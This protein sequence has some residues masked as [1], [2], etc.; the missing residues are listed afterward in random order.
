MLCGRERVLTLNTVC[1]CLQ[2][3][4]SRIQQIEKDMLRLGARLQVPC[5]L[6]AVIPVISCQQLFL[7]LT[8]FL[9]LTRWRELRGR[10]KAVECLELR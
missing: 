5:P 1:L 4:V 3:R 8:P 6:A 10:M 2:T 7:L 9:R